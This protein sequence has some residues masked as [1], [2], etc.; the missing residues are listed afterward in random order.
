M[1]ADLPDDA[2]KMQARYRE[3]EEENRL[4]KL[5]LKKMESKVQSLLR[6]YFGRSS[7][8]MD[9]DQL[10][11]G[12]DAVREDDFLAEEPSPV[13]EPLGAQAAPDRRAA[14]P[15]D[16]PPRASTRAAHGPRRHAACRHP[17]GDH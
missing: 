7:E 3:L 4:L 11:L 5:Q 14:H 16:R 8:T 17:R 12:L 9:P 2:A 1:S 13:P 6:Q 10:Q 15:G